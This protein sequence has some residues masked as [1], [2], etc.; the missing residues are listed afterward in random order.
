VPILSETSGDVVTIRFDHAATRNGLDLETIPLLRDAIRDAA[1]SAE[2]RFLVLRGVKD[3]FCIGGSGEFM[4]YLLEQGLE[5]RARQTRAVQSIVLEWLRS[6]LLTVALLDGL[7][8]GAGADLVLA[9]DL[10][11]ATDQ[12]R[13]SLLYARLGLVPDTGFRLLDRRLGW[14]A[15]LAFAESRV[16]RAGELV[17]R[18]LAEAAGDLAEQDR[19]LPWLRRRFRHGRDA[20]AAAKGLRNHELLATIEEEFERAAWEQARALD[21]PETRERLAHSAATQRGAV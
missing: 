21:R 15:M 9:S 20:F 10:V 14:Q 19:L 4:E 11:L 17:E 6:P 13:F 12:A 3:W 8:A 18:G 2:A 16:L 1:A 5:E 7:A